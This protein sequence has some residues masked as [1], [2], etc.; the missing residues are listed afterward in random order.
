MMISPWE[1]REGEEGLCGTPLLCALLLHR[2]LS[3]VVPL[4]LE[5]ADC[6]A[7]KRKGGRGGE[8]RARAFQT[9]S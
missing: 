5:E 8:L 7:E 9:R 1:G 2:L 3:A 6:S 4:S